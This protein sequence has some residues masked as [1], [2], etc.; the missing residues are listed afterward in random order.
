MKK[1]NSFTIVLLLL[2]SVLKGVGHE[3]VAGFK[4]GDVLPELS[5]HNLAGKLISTHDYKGNIILVDFWASWCSPCREDNKKMVEIYNSYEKT[6]FKKGNKF[7]IFSVSLDQNIKSWEN[8]IS[9]DGMRWKTQVSDLA[10][11]RSQIKNTAK[12][13]SIPANYL[14]DGK[15]RILAVNLTPSELER[16]LAELKKD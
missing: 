10:G 2:L 3:N 6:R 12:V 13:A 1:Q 9:E 14:I 16:K 8:A 4:Q 15:G 11:S 5:S 7:I